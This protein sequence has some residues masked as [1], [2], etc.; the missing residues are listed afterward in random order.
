[1]KVIS[2]SI[3]RNAKSARRQKASFPKESVE[4]VDLYKPV[5]NKII[6]TRLIREIEFCSSFNDIPFFFRSTSNLFFGLEIVFFF[7]LLIRQKTF[8]DTTFFFFLIS[9]GCTVFS[10]WISLI[11]KLA[12]NIVELT[13]VTCVLYTFSFRCITAIFFNLLS[14]SPIKQAFSY[15]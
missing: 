3:Q 13:V 2:N 14:V 10:T 12:V 8:V 15:F 9:G 1:M 7:I 4:N 5:L 6:T 11:R